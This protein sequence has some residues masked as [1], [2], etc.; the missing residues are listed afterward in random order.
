MDQKERKVRKNQRRRERTSQMRQDSLSLEYIRL[1]YNNIY[2]EANEFYRS[3]NNKYS[4][5][6]DLRKTEDFK[7]FK[8]DMA[9]IEKPIEQ[10]SEQVSDPRPQTPD[11]PNPP[12]PIR[13][14]FGER[15]I[16]KDTMRLRIPLMS[17]DPVTTEIIQEGTARTPPP[18][19][20]DPVT[21]EII[22]EDTAR[23]PPPVTTGP[24]TTEIIQEGTART[25]L[26]LPPIQLQPKYYPWLLMKY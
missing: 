22:Q 18:V 4:E 26:Q 25:P 3:L 14:R 23:T 5:K 10:V 2:A 13:L 6:L 9:R 15:C 24:V 16:Y 8:A 11:F 19:T 7:V 20:T 1:K 17:T 12:A 21:T